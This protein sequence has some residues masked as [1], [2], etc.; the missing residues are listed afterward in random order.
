MKFQIQ[1]AQN[2]HVY[3]V[4]Y[5]L[6][7]LEKEHDITGFD[8]EQFVR[9]LFDPQSMMLL[10]TTLEEKAIGFIHARNEDNKTIIHFL[11][12]N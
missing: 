10:A 3:A 6:E 7:Q 5:L 1:K 9:Y 4:T 11:D 12:I 2:E 8:D